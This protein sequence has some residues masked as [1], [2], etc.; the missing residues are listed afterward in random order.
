MDEGNLLGRLSQA[1]AALI[2]LYVKKPAVSV[3]ISVTI[4]M[5]EFV[6][7]MLRKLYIFF[8]AMVYNL[9]TVWVYVMSWHVV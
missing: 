6:K 1:H 8:L 2:Q 5:S 7:I 3:C 4:T 9:S